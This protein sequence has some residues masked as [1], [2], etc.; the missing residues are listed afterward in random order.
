MAYEASKDKELWS[1]DLGTIV[2]SVNQYNGGDPKVGI[3]R[4]FEGKD[5]E[6]KFGKAGRLTMD[7]FADIVAHADEINKAAGKGKKTKTKKKKSK[8]ADDDDE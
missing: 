3:V 5:G 8:K 2:V 6:V 4:K 1:E 7:E